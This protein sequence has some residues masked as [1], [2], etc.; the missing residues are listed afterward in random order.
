MMNKV[1]FIGRS[2]ID[3]TYLIS[4]Y[5]PENTKQF[6]TDYLMQYGGPALNAAITCSLLGGRS[7]ILSGFGT[8]SAGVKMKTDLKNC[9]GVS[10]VDLVE[11]DK[12]S[13]PSSAIMVNSQH[14]TRTIINSPKANYEPLPDYSN[15]ELSHFKLILWDGYNYSPDLIAKID[16]AKKCGAELVLDC[17]SWKTA[18]AEMLSR[19]DYAICSQAFLL[20]HLDQMETIAYLHDKNIGFVAFTNNDKP[21]LVSENANSSLI[22]VEQTSAIDTLGAGD[23]FHG[24][25]CYYLSQGYKAKQALEFS[26]HIATKSCQYFGTH[27]WKKHD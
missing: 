1:A 15:V 16:E 6:A 5:P 25:F 23:V 8:S 22:E 26:A 4:E 21:I 3:Y 13:L 12:F 18:Y 10:S 11:S 9:Y 27:T 14:A 2:T 24:A 19:V 20:P 17:G 7:T